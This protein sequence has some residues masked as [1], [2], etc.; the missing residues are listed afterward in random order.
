VLAP[1]S[2]HASGRA[3]CW[4]ADSGPD[5][6]RLAELPGWLAQRLKQQS[7]GKA[8]RVED[9]R[10]LTA[11]GVADGARND[12]AVQLVGHLLARGVDPFVTLELLLAWDAHRNRPPLGGDVI[13]RTVNSIAR[14]EAAKWGV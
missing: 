12:R 1:P 13:A 7:N 6:V 8:H 2:L 3:Y 10:Q 11:N 9:W 5:D 14:R 4:V